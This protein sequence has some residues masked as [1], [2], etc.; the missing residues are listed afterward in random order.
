MDKAEEKELIR[1]LIKSIQ[2]NDANLDYIAKTGIVN[3]S[4]WLEI[5]R[6]LKQYATEV[7]REKFIRIYHWLNE[8]EQLRN[9][10]IPLRFKDDFISNQEDR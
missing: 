2:V 4:L 6:I 5:E 1:K 10:A 3:G 7:S 9:T 8:W